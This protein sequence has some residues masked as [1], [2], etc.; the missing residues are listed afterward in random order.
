MMRIVNMKRAGIYVVMQGGAVANVDG[1]SH[2][3]ALD[4]L[5]TALRRS[6]L[7]AVERELTTKA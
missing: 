7:T 5:K 4:E 6:G 2:W 1:R 3:D